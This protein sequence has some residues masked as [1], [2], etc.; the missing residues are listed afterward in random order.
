MSRF[1][2]SFVLDYRLSFSS[3]AAKIRPSNILMVRLSF[4]A[5][6]PHPNRNLFILLFVFVLSDDRKGSRI[7][8][9][10]II[11][12][13]PKGEVYRP[14]LVST[15][16]TGSTLSR[17]S[18]FRTLISQQSRA[19]EPAFSDAKTVSKPR[20]LGPGTHELFDWLA[21][22]KVIF[23]VNFA[24]ACFFSW[25]IELLGSSGID[26]SLSKYPC[27]KVSVDFQR[28]RYHHVRKKTHFWFE[29]WIFSCW[30]NCNFM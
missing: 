4:E 27:T 7:N 25:T 13:Q 6:H 11:S 21:F 16:R 24:L 5:K 8:F 30:R 17:K 28:P 29:T 3:C 20:S 23:G 14:F 9:N 12:C 2:K 22:S 18:S 19:M 15:I 10:V 1:A 26:K